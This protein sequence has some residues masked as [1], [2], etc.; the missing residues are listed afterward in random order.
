[1]PATITIE[2]K[3][4]RFFATHGWHDEEAILGAEFEVTILA[5]LP[6]VENIVSIADTVDYSKM[7]AIIKAVF[8]EREKLLETVA[9]KI[10]T[11]LRTTFTQ[12]EE[13]KISIT[14]L[15]PPIASFIGT[16][17]ITYTKKI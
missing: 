6:A 4:L 8:L 7:Y 12:L 15:S 16:V 17:G 2:L 10:E 3:N 14:K 11:A 13:I 9:Q 1:M 5:T